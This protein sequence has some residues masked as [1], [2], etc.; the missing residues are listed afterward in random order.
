MKQNSIHGE[1]N[2]LL[3]STCKSPKKQR[4]EVAVTKTFCAIS[5]I[6]SVSQRKM[7]NVSN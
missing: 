2:F 5:H 6:L 4:E 7:V 1:D 3:T